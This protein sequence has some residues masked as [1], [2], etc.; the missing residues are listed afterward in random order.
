MPFALYG[1]Q[2][3]VVTIPTIL[4]LGRVL[5]EIHFEDAASQIFY[6]QKLFLMGGVFLIIQLLWGHKLP[7][8]IGPASV[9]LIGIISSLSFSYSVIYTSVAIGGG[10]L[11][12]ISLSGLLSKIDFLFTP[13]IIVVILLLIAFTLSPVIIDLMYESSAG[14][15][16]FHFWFA[17]ISVLLMLLMN[18]WFVGIWKSVVVLL[19]LVMGTLVYP[20]FKPVELLQT[21]SMSEMLLSSKTSLFIFPL[22]F[23]IGVIIAFLFCFLALLINELGSIQSVGSMLNLK[24]L[25]KRT[26]QG[27]AVTGISNIV[28]GFVG[29]IGLVDFSFSPGVIS[30]TKCASR[31]VL[32]PV[33]IGLIIIA[34]FPGLVNILNQTPSL[35][36]GA[37]MFYLMVNQLAS[38]F[39]LMQRQKAIIDFE[40]A[41][42]IGFP[43]ML[44]V[45]VSFMPQ[46]VSSSIPQLLRPILTNG[47][48]MGVI[49]VIVC[50]HIIFKRKKT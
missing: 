34:L 9:L 21:V 24:D 38:G 32:I 12:L 18:K 41:V 50:E 10:F 37:I 7:L 44:A 42:V 47:F 33:G 48:V 22:E 36:I 27:V 5:A 8:I 31:Y 15:E 39:D 49:A 28:A 17:I 45:L 35:V 13:R 11:L 3:L 46:S 16:S 30:S 6:T 20:Q 25:D 29:V 40:S 2:W 23:D 43:I 4:I 26:Q 1:L 19:G 14:Y